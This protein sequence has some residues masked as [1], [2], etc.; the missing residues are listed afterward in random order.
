[1]TVG[2]GLGMTD[3]EWNDIVKVNFKKEQDETN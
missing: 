1:M 3:A 2:K